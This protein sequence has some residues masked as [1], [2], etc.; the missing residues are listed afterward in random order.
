VVGL[1]ATGLGMIGARPSTSPGTTSSFD[2]PVSITS[3]GTHVWVADYS[4]DSVTEL[5]AQTGAVIETI[6][7]GKST[8]YGPSA[9]SSNGGR[10]WVAS[11][12]GVA[13][14]EL[15]ATTGKL[16]QTLPASTKPGHALDLAVYGS[17]L[18]VASFDPASVREFNA[19]TGALIRSLSARKYKELAKLTYVAADASHVWVLG[20]P[21]TELSESTGVPIREIGGGASHLFDLP[22]A[23]SDDGIHVWVANFKSD[24]V[25]E[26]NARTGAVVRVIQG[27][28]HHLTRMF[29]L[30]VAI[31]SD[32]VH[33]WVTNIG[34][35]SVTEL[36]A[37]TGALIKVLKGAQ[38]GFH[39]PY[40]ISSDGVHVWIANDTGNSVTE[41][42]AR[43]GALVRVIR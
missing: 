30:P 25:V 36:N 21:L 31:A 12:S 18:W 24:S 40:G 34:N 19:G 42:N 10:V 13:V 38:F 17:R 39:L 14:S 28:K 8:P 29:S 22:R 33:V 11:R 43:T 5:K 26:I 9:I 20:P 35:D 2:H 23:M 3:D 32:R 27:P 37:R 41:L 4:N 1:L 6:K 15:N 7:L 16:I